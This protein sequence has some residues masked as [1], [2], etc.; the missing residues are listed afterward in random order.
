[1]GSAGPYGTRVY[2]A[3]RGFHGLW[4]KGDCPTDGADSIVI[5]ENAPGRPFRGCPGAGKRNYLLRLRRMAS[6]P[7]DSGIKLIGSGTAV[8]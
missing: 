2:D 1:M 4:A 6:K 3:D 8:V 5:N 7:R